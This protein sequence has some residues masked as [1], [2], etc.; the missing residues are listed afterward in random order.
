MKKLLLLTCMICI[1]VFSNSQNRTMPAHRTCGTPQL[2]AEYENWLQPKI[3]EFL[4]LQQTGRVQTSYNIPVVV[5]IIHNGEAIGTGTNLSIA[6]INSQID[7]LNE[8]FRKQ[9]AD[10]ATVPAAFKPFITDSEINFHLATVTPGGAATTGIDRINRNTMGWSAPPYTQSYINSTIKPT[11]IW[12]PKKYMN[13][14]VMNLGGGLLGYATFPPNS[15]LN[16]ISGGGTLTTD[17]VV[18]L[19]DA[20]GRTGT[21]SPPYHKGR[22]ATHEVGHYLGLRHIWG[23]G[24]CPAPNN[25][26]YC[27]DTP[28]QDGENYGCPTYPLITANAGMGWFGP[29]CSGTA[30]GSMFMNYMDY[31]DD[32]CMKMFSGDQKTRMQTAMANSNLRDSL[33]TGPTAISENSGRL[34]SVSVYPNPSKGQITISAPT[35]QAG[36]D[37]EINV[38]NILGKTVFHDRVKAISQGIYDLNLTSLNSGLYI[39]ELKNEKGNYTQRIDINK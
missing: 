32:A 18:I 2:P 24:S 5:H 21:V 33:S 31:V 19:Y 27:N 9:N 35:I 22:T 16:G 11:T 34:Q 6:Q 25:N 10:T 1:A 8:D 39:V 29:S 20:F 26:D 13:M 23:D 37:L 12:N 28:P 17:G 3:K 15:G 38:I 30:P 7:V 14:W 36:T 4:E